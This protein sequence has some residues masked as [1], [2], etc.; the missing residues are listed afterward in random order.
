MGLPRNS[1]WATSFMTVA[2]APEPGV[3]GVRVS[4]K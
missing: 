1:L 3:H 2:G 4:S